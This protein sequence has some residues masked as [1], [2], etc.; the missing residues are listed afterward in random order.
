MSKEK[1]VKQ[2]WDDKAK[3]SPETIFKDRYFKKVETDFISS[4]LKSKDVVLD[5]GCG[6]G[7]DTLLYA[8]KVKKIYG[9]DYSQEMTKAS[10][11]L[12]KVENAVF[13]TM[14]IRNLNLKSNFFDK[15]IGEY[16]LVNLPSWKDQQKGIKEIYRVLK[17]RG[18]YIMCEATQQGLVDVDKYRKMF[19]IEPLK[20][21]WH[22]VYLNEVQLGRC[23]ADVGFE[24][25]GSRRFG[26]YHFISKI[27]HP[28]LVYPEEP[29]FE[30]EI[31][32]VAAD[33]ERKLQNNFPYCSHR[34]MW[35]WRK[36]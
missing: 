24:L 9:V 20:R 12:S 29:Q 4:L 2:Y 34:V 1:D 19:N 11:N 14:D 5:V 26:M 33:I 8:E 23:C 28:L 15:V 21:H 22:N 6:V 13:A 35:V 25:V 36:I 31:N 32:R 3:S 16:V 7:A 10:K 17:P 18:L 30:A 27:I